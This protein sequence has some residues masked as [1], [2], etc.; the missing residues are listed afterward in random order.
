MTFA[1]KVLLIV[2]AVP[3]G[4]SEWCRGRLTF[5]QYLRLLV[6]AVAWDECTSC[7]G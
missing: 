5:G 7:G 4:L 6:A 2:A 1:F 3:L